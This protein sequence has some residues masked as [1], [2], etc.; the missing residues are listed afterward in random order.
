[1]A[2]NSD[3]KQKDVVTV[4]V[5]DFNRMRDSVIL[6]F[7]TIQSAISE[8]SRAYVNQTNKILNRESSTLD[9]GGITASL[10]EKGLFPQMQNVQAT[11][12]ATEEAGEKAKKKRKRVHDPNAPKRALTPFFLYM[13]TNRPEITKELG[14]NAR[15]KDVADEGTRRWA[16]MSESEKEIWKNIYKE[17]LARYK[18][19]M[20]AYKAGLPIPEDDAH[21]DE[22]AKQLQQG[23]DNAA[24]SM[25]SEESSDS[26][27]EPSPEPEPVK[28]PTPPRSQKRRRTLEAKNAFDASPAKKGS[29][30][31]KK[32]A[33]AAEEKVEKSKK[34]AVVETPKSE[35]K[36]KKRKSEVQAEE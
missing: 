36:K 26:E 11:G 22:A 7:A 17:N 24:E 23:I 30:E 18:E 2:R 8:L 25:S 33:K 5:E 14:P 27:E 20:K 15:P 4:S 1:M 6:G 12:A 13:K 3:E 10:L 16:E 9:L 29:P 19:K 21:T 35:K 34:P 28:E 32:K 31:K